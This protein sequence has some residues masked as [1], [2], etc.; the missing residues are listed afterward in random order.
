MCV[1]VVDDDEDLRDTICDVLRDAGRLVVCAAN[2][3]EALTLLGTMPP[4]C[5][6]LIDLMMPVMSGWQLVESIRRRTELAALPIVIMSATPYDLPPRVT[7]LRKPFESVD[8]AKMV[9]R[10]R[11]HGGGCTG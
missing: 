7:L 6:A 10:Y 4:P 5:V 2:G 9:A 1:L 3:G 11:C 8:L